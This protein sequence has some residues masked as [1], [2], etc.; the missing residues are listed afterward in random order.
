MLAAKERVAGDAMRDGFKMFV[1]LF[2]AI[3]GGSIALRVSPADPKLLTAVAPLA[4][5]LVVFVGLLAATSGLTNQAI[6][7]S[8]Q[9]CNKTSNSVDVTVGYAVSG[10]HLQ[11]EGWWTLA[12]R[13]GCARVLSRSQT[14]DYTSGYLYA[15]RKGGNR[16]VTG[17]QSLCVQNKPFT[18]RRHQNCEGRNFR[19]VQARQISINLNKNFTTNITTAA[20]KPGG[21]KFDDD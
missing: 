16:V 17:D 12:P 15:E 10:G 14:V 20:P 11:S 19:T 2:S 18:I 7:Q 13:G 3:V 6:A 21:V 4:A 1:Q 8:W 9:I 5:V